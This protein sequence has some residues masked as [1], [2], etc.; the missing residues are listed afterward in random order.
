MYAPIESSPLLAYAGLIHGR[1]TIP[2]S[3]E[4]EPPKPTLLARLS[5]SWD[6]YNSVLDQHPLLVKG[7]T[8]FFVLG[9]GDLC[10]QGFEHWQGT[11]T[12]AGV[13]WIRALRFGAFGLVG[14]PWAHYYFYYLD[15]FFPPTPEPFTR[16]TWIKLLIDQ[17]IQ[18]PLLLAVIIA[19][20]A[21]LKGTGIKGVEDDLE[22]NYVD[23]LFANCT[24][25][26]PT[27]RRPACETSHWLQGSS[28]YR[29]RL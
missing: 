11:A 22:T 15:Y 29:H 13:D 8:A 27:L 2:P 14:A 21:I 19:A 7:I 18:A 3:Q 25:L 4:E 20:L 28:G 6:D 24:C 10:G 26:P 5:S 23:A 9:L 16:T 1:R 12:V 17:G